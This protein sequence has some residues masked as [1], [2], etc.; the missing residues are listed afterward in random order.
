[1]GSDFF[2][3]KQFVI[4]QKNSAM[5]VG[6]DGMLIGAWAEINGG[7]RSILD[8]GCGTG[9]IA[10]MLAQRNQTAAVDAIE[11]EPLAAAEA[12][13]NAERSPWADRITVHEISLQEYT[14]SNHRRY[15][16]I[17]SN[18][19]YFINSSHNEKLAR[20]AARHASLLP[21]SDL[22]FGVTK[23][24]N[25]NGRFFAIFPYA[26][27]GIFIA[28]ASLAGLYCNRKLNIYSKQAGVIKRIAAEFSFRKTE[29][30]ESN[31]II[32]K[33]NG[34]YTEEYKQLTSP[35]YLRF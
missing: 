7:E 17:V 4:E 28:K 33:D 21:Y 20:A 34:E 10:I 23:L 1:M 11:I 14:L 5:R 15:D 18:P 25:E 31:F 8:I 35:F 16:M 13:L 32:N 19:P 24:L 12:A 29:V 27:A 26:E 6:T 3:F 2:Q 30:V 9:L 22:I